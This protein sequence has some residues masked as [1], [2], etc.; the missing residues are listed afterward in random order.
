MIFLGLKPY[1]ISII[2]LI[3]ANLNQTNLKN[4]IMS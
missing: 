3:D 1:N 2:T 4:K